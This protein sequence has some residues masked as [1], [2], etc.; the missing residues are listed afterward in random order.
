MANKNKLRDAAVKIGST[1]GKVDAAAHRAALKAARAAHVA[2]Q[3]LI[4][5]SKQVEALKSQL[6]KSTKKLKSALK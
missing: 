5:V 6:K 3:E 4:E 2:R 1:V